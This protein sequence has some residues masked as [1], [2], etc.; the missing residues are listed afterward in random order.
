M[1]SWED[2]CSELLKDENF[3]EQLSKDNSWMNDELKI[4]LGNARMKRKKQEI[5][6]NI[7]KIILHVQIITSYIS[8]SH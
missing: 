3:G 1:G 8:I 5:F 7:C 4:A 2:V 6:I